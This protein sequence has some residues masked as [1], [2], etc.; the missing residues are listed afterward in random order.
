[1]ESPNRLTSAIASA[2]SE[3]ISHRR[4]AVCLTL[5]IHVSDEAA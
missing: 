3:E 1:M 4:V 2:N 5:A